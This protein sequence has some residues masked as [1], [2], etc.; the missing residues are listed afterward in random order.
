MTV[1]HEKQKEM[2]HRTPLLLFI[3]CE[4]GSSSKNDNNKK[5]HIKMVYMIWALYYNRNLWWYFFV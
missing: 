1:F 4:W 2:L 3:E 5:I